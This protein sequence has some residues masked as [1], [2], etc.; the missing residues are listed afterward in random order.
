M[1]DHQKTEHH[2]ETKTFE[3]VAFEMLSTVSPVKLPRE[4]IPFDSV[5]K[6][7]LNEVINILV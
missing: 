4:D 7:I 1:R 6:I 2:H 5:R 3:D